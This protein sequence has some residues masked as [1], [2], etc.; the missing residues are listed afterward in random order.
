MPGHSLLAVLKPMFALYLPVKIS[1]PLSLSLSRTFS[2]FLLLSLADWQT[3]RLGNLA[4]WPNGQKLGNWKEPR[5]VWLFMFGF[6]HLEEFGLVHLGSSSAQ[7]SAESS[8]RY[9]TILVLFGFGFLVKGSHFILF[10]FGL[11]AFLYLHSFT[12]TAFCPFS[13]LKEIHRL[14]AVC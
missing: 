6:V 9:G 5:T 11:T 10:C 4:S 12:P 3:D 7:S 8:V 13:F 1:P 2:F 14:S